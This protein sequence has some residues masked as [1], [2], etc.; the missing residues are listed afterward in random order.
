MRALQ[1][2]FIKRKLILRQKFIRS[3]FSI[4][5]C[6]VHSQYN[7]RAKDTD[8]CACGSCALRAMKRN[9]TTLIFHIYKHVSTEK[10]Q[11]RGHMIEANTKR[12]ESKYAN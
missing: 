6:S 5:A 2:V 8:V 12:N 4:G 1:N 7:V 9:I 10:S 11:I 3:C